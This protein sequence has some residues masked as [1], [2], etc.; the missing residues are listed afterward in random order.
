[1]RAT[2]HAPAREPE[3]VIEGTVVDAK[4]HEPV[5]GATVV[6]TPLDPRAAEFR[7]SSYN[8]FRI[9]LPP[10]TYHGHVY[11]ADAEIPLADVVVKAGEVARWDVEL[12]HGLVERVADDIQ[13]RCSLSAQLSTSASEVEQLLG[14]V[15]ARFV[16]DEESVPDGSMLTRRDV[17]YIAAEVGDHAR[18]TAG[19]LPGASSRPLVVKTR[20]ELQAIADRTGTRFPY[21]QITSA[22]ITGDCATVGVGVYIMQPARKQEMLL[23]CC[24]TTDV[25]VKRGG[26]WQ[27]KVVAQQICA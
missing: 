2:S 16:Q 8:G 15:L 24:S 1:M 7:A 23:C 22:E 4:T 27:F 10:G 19:A 18:V 6:A 12:E 9:E 13:P 25:Y 3:A 11:V 14:E 17:I 5:E 21:L 26:K 20:D